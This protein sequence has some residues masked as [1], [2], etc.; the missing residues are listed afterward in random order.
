MNI[1]GRAKV[2]AMTVSKPRRIRNFIVTSEFLKT[3]VVF[4]V[5]YQREVS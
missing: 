2:V 4:L 1:P 3:S 5:G